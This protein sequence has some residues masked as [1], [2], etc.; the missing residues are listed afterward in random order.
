MKGNKKIRVDAA[1]E[2]EANYRSP[3][4]QLQHLDAKGFTA[5]KERAK[6]ARKLSKKKKKKKSLKQIAKEKGMDLSK[7]KESDTE[8]DI[9]TGKRTHND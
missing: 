3:A 8:I 4:E 1:Q 6:L 9:L 7:I 2:R 5:E